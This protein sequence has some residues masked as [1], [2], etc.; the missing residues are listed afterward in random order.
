MTICSG[1]NLQALK[2]EV[3]SAL[4]GKRFRL[5]LFTSWTALLLGTFMALCTRFFWCL[6]SG[7]CWEVFSLDGDLRRGRQS[8]FGRR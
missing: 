3:Y 5:T 1:Q 8:R 7:G 4:A 2:E 6:V